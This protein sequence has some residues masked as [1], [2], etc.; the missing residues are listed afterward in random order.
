MGRRK[1]DATITTSGPDAPKKRSQ[2]KVTKEPSFLISFNP[3]ENL[4]PDEKAQATKL[5]EKGEWKLARTHEDKARDFLR[6]CLVKDCLKNEFIK[7]IVDNVMTKYQKT[8]PDDYN[9]FIGA[10]SEIL[11]KNEPNDKDSEIV[12]SQFYERLREMGAN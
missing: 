10:I 6:Y 12:L 11:A 2:S 4:P 1:K 7:N 5:I 8:N 3:Y 9:K